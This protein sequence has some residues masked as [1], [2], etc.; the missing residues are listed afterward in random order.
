MAPAESLCGC[1]CCSF[2]FLFKKVA[3]AGLC[4]GA[5]LL[6]AYADTE[7][8]AGLKGAVSEGGKRGDLRILRQCRDLA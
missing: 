4:G 2:F 8:P 6:C 7:M 3:V 5:Y 1:K